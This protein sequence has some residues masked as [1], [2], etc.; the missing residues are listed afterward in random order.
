M[1]SQL[2]DLTADLNRDTFAKIDVSQWQNATVQVVGNI[3]GTINLTGTNDA[4]SVQGVTDG[5][6]TSSL[7]YT[8][9]QATNLA[10]G[11]AVTAVA[12]AGNFKIVV[13]TKFIQI[14]GTNAAVS[15]KLL[16]FCTTPV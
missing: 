14:G 9:V 11:S 7:N 15:G 3:T 5:N 1:L 6:A 10:T 4:G 13:G 8:A 2:F 12:A 16:V